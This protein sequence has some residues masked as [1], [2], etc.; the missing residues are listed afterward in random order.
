MEG[1]RPEVAEGQQ[2]GSEAG[3]LSPLPRVLTLTQVAMAPTHSGNSPGAPSPCNA[4]PVPS[5]EKARHGME[6]PLKETP[7]G[8]LLFMPEPA[9]KRGFG[10]EMQ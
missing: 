3:R 4:P 5:T 1:L 9:W 6:L 7:G 10:P 8:I 2:K